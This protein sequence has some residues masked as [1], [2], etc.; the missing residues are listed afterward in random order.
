MQQDGLRGL[1]EERKAREKSHPLCDL[2]GLLDRH[3]E[4]LQVQGTLVPSLF[5][6]FL[7]IQRKQGALI[8][9]YLS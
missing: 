8:I 5:F 1:Q 4:A 6:L 2:Q 3:E 9:F 7:Y